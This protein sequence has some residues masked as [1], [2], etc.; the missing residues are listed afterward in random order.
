MSTSHDSTVY[1]RNRKLQL[2]GGMKF[3]HQTG[4]L[5]SHTRPVEQVL[6]RLVPADVPTLWRKH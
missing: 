6:P 5:R 2:D 1:R 4:V 3:R